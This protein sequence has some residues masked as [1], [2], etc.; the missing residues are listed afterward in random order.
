MK[1]TREDKEKIAKAIQKD[2]YKE[3]K[4]MKKVF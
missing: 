2:Q 3:E 1:M 4:M